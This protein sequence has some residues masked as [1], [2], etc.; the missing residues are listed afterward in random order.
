MPSALGNPITG[1]PDTSLNPKL[2]FAKDHAAFILHSVRDVQI[3][4]APSI[5]TDSFVRATM[6]IASDYAL[7]WKLEN[8]ERRHR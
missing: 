1:N 2:T 6:T 5:P 4:G 8:I 7:S 3:H